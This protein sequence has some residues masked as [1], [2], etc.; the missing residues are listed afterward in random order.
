[1]SKPISVLIELLFVLSAAGTFFFPH[2]VSGKELIPIITPGMGGTAYV[3]GAGI[4]NIAKKYIPDIE[5][6]VQGESG[7][8]TMLKLMHDFYLKGRPAFTVCDSNGVWSAY[9]G[10]GLFHGREKLTGL[11]AIT[12]L[13]GAEVFLV[14]SKKSGIKSFQDTRGKRIA[15]GPPGSS[16]AAS[17]ALLFEYNGLMPK[18]D[19][20]ALYLSYNEVADGIKDNS[21]DAGI[22]AGTAPVAA[23]NELS[24]THDVT[25]IP[26]KPEVLKAIPEKYLYYYPSVIKKGSYRGIDADVPTIAFGVMLATHEKTDNELVYQVVKTLYEK[27][28]ELVAISKSAE[29]MTPESALKSL[30]V[31]LHEG[32]KKYFKE[33]GVVK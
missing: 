28:K 1:M 2:P 4:G 6:V 20:E 16:V 11:R 7:S 32:A 10:V 26:V 24:L 30:G 21:I 27:R 5:T 15:L 33:I 8:T 13:Y 31:P 25:I 29:Q 23:Y 12:F 17:G 18:K 22:L 3:L 9:N 14:T 19:F